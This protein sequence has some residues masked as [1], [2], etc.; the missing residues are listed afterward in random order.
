MARPAGGPAPL[1]GG[2]AFLQLPTVDLDRSAAFYETAF[3]WSV[4]R[5]GGSFSGAGLHGQLTTDRAPAPDAGALVWLWADDLS[6]VL[7]DVTAAG[8]RVLRAPALD[9][10]RRWQ[11]EVADPAGN[12]LGVA[13]PAGPPKAQPLLAVRD[14]EAASR[15]Y[16]ALLGLESDHGGPEYERLLDRP[17][18][19]IVLQLHRWD[20]GHDH[21]A[22]GDPDLPHGNG[23]LVWFGDVA[24]LDAVVRR[25]RDLGVEIVLDEHRNPP[26][27]AGNGPGHREL[28]V[29]D[30][31]GYVVV[32]A[33][34][35]GEAFE[36]G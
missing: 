21:G 32:A 10:G 7:H 18:G 20:V 22:I 4:D 34:P 14:V 12:R 13:V 9:G 26:S 17:G 19:E 23:A 31:D 36:P 2:V 30:L 5:A 33:S 35:D 1:R 3:G 27:G 16:Q 11:V 25:A 28:W 8:G 24:D 15:W 29:R 6:R